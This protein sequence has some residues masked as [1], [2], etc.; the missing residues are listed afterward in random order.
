MIENLEKSIPPSVPS[1]N[2]KKNKKHS[3]KRDVATFHDSEEEDS[4]EK[5]KGKT[6]CKFHG[7][8]GHITDEH[9]SLKA[10]IRQAK[11]KKGK[12][13]KRYKTY[14]K[15]E[16]NIMVWWKSMSRKCFRRKTRSVWKKLCA[17]QKVSVSDSKQESIDG[18]SIKESKI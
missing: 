6:F 13:V 4:D 8:C 2:K 5:S 14:T 12:Q 1:R 16:V 10:L 7:T 11:Q 9:I 15:Q 18:S 3:K 17:F